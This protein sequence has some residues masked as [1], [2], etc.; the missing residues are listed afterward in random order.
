MTRRTVNLTDA[1]HE[2]L[3]DH[4]LRESDILRRLREETARREQHSRTSARPERTR[5]R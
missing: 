5:E 2:Y 4:S 1:L 3:L